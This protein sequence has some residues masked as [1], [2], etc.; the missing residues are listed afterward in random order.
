MKVYKYFFFALFL[1]PLVIRA[2]ETKELVLNA[3]QLAKY[4]KSYKAPE[5]IHLRKFLDTYVNARDKIEP[6]EENAAKVLDGMKLDPAILKARFIVYQYAN[7]IGGGKGVSIVSQE[8]PEVILDF[9]VYKT[10]GQNCEVRDLLIQ[11]DNR[12]IEQFKTVYRQF[13]NNKTLAM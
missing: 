11:D 10:D 12:N 8:H 4:G 6:G 1:L 13:L 7:I 5:V 2:Q 3:Q 9:W